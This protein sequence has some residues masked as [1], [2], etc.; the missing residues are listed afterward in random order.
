MSKRKWRKSDFVCADIGQV[1]DAVTF[2][3]GVWR[4]DIGR[5]ANRSWVMSQQ[6]H[7]LFMCIRMGLF[8][9]PERV[10][11]LAKPTKK[12]TEHV[13]HQILP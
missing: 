8:W 11:H 13:H 7:Y 12:G 6:L 3:G 2:C 9:Y 5:F 4:N 10:A 1:L